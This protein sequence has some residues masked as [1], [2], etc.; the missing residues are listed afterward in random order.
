M[1]R[2]KKET[3]LPVIPTQTNWIKILSQL[4]L[5]NKF[6]RFQVTTMNSQTKCNYYLKQYLQAV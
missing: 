4:N 2:T 5:T 3:M 6:L 1:K